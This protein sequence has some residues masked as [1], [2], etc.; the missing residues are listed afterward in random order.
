MSASLAAPGPIPNSA[1]QQHR[2]RLFYA[3]AAF[4]ML[5]L[6]L[7]GFRHFYLEGRA[8][9]GRELPPPIRTLII[10]HGVSMSVWVLLFLGQCLL[11]TAR[12]V[13]VHMM[14]GRVAALF[15]LAILVSGLLLAVASTR[16]AP[17]G[18]TIWSR[19]PKQFLAVPFLSILLFGG[20]VG[21]AV[22]YRKVPAIHRPMMFFATLNALGAA[23]SRID[24]INGWYV[25]TAW[26]D[27]FGPFLGVLALGA[28][29]VLVK[30]WMTR[31][32]DK[33]FALSYG[34]VLVVL[35]AIVRISA[36]PAW[37]RFADLLV[38]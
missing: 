26:E 9:P 29:L 25:G 35:L 14:V 28:V 23:T 3:G 12:K 2:A 21:V 15:A 33:W 32:F 22:W 17:P 8:H 19:T 24:L 30:W 6:M 27:I 36:T 1:A 18:L 7:I 31:T 16:A 4:L 5:V 20:M 38:G 10:L 34:V 37:E 13:R 11:V